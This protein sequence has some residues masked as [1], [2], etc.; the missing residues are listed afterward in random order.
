LD[1]RGP[2]LVEALDRRPL[3][4][5]PNRE[6]L[7]ATVGGSLT[8]DDALLAAMRGLNERGAQWVVVTQGKDAVWVS[9]RQECF[10]ITPPSVPVVNPIGAGDC[11][12]A[13][14]SWKLSE[15]LAV[16]QAVRWGVAAAA[17]NVTQLLPARLDRAAVARLA[18][19]IALQRIA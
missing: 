2:E 14:T 13:G 10:R 1:V 17:Y 12:A 15:G 11:L 7:A 19:T 16:P 4:V 9:S 18:E 8:T 5:K 6:E 3:L